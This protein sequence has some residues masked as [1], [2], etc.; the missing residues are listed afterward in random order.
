MFL[1][2]LSLLE[3]HAIFCENKD[4]KELDLKSNNISH[5]INTVDQCIT[6]CKDLELNTDTF[7]FS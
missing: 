4:M 3:Q 6:V 5:L 1:L 7:F 2:G